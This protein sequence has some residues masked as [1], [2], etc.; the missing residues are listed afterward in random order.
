MIEIWFEVDLIPSTCAVFIDELSISFLA[1]VTLSQIIP[2]NDVNYDFSQP[3]KVSIDNKSLFCLFDDIIFGKHFTVNRTNNEK[4]RTLS[5][6]CI[7]SGLKDIKLPQGQRQLF[8]RR[9]FQNVLLLNKIRSAMLWCLHN[10]G[11]KSLLLWPSI[12][13]AFACAK[14]RV[15][16]VNTKEMKWKKAKHEKKEKE[17]ESEK[18]V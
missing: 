10:W 7:F 9:F 15:E 3:G 11:H 5:T 17:R 14:C 12:H 6:F 18:C 8:S 4:S 2:K 13:N 1:D 16:A